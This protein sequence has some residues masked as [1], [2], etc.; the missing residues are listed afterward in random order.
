MDVPVVGT[1]DNNDGIQASYNLGKGKWQTAFGYRHFRSFRHFVGSVEQ[2]A[3]NA[4]RGLAERDRSATNVINH[5]HQPSVGVSYGVT[6]RFSVSADL[7]YFHALRRSPVSGSRPSF[8]T[9]A[10]GVSDATITGRYWLGDPR[11]DERRVGKESGTRSA[12]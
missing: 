12:T 8:A 11:S 7:P 9:K 2:N 3:D 1:H 4:A 6:D 10:S 5:V